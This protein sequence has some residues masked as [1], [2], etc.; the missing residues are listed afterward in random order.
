MDL[1]GGY[2]TLQLLL[3]R[4]L[5]STIVPCT[6]VAAAQHRF[7]AIPEPSMACLV[8]RNGS[9]LIRCGRRAVNSGARM[10]ET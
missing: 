6:T 4:S 7:L 9:A 8:K 1:I 3:Q 5:V 10:L 2:N